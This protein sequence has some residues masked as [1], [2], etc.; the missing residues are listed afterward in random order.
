LFV[1]RD[2]LPDVLRVVSDVMPL[3]YAVDGMQKLQQSADV[4]GDF[5]VDL[6]VI[7]A[8]IVAAV[9]FGAATLKRRT[10]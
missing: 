4:S 2:D 8:F 3:S 7:A 9:G 1:A 6:L 10:A 5:V